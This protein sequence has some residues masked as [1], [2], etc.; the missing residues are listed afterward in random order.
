ME[1]LLFTLVVERDKFN[2]TPP[3]CC[4]LPISTVYRVRT[5][6]RRP[7]ILI[8]RDYEQSFIFLSIFGF[9]ALLRQFFFIGFRL[10]GAN[11]RRKWSLHRKYTNEANILHVELNIFSLRRVYVCSYQLLH[12]RTSKWGF[13]CAT[14]SQSNGICANRA[15]NILQ[16]FSFY[17]IQ[18]RNRWE[19]R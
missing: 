9:Q 13:C 6:Q 15:R 4:F 1:D 12:C 19:E 11:F 2:E 8:M 3:V 16:F 18:W 7:H 10:N 5:V 17:Q 14:H